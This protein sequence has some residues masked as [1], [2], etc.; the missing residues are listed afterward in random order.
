MDKRLL[1]RAIR[2]GY[3]E[4]D[5]VDEQCSLPC[6]IG[7]NY[8]IESIIDNGYIHESKVFTTVQQIEDAGYIKKS[9]LPNKDIIEDEALA[10]LQEFA[11]FRELMQLDSVG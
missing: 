9:E 7:I 4:H 2:D 8:I 11:P 6:K 5:C 10:P 3:M 1:E